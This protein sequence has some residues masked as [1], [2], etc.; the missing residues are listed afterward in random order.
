MKSRTPR[1][2]ATVLRY[3]GESAA[4]FNNQHYL[5][6]AVLLGVAAE[7]LLEQLYEALATHLGSAKA[8]YTAKLN[9]KRWTSQ[10]LEYARARLAPHL[11][12]VTVE[13]RTRV[14]QYLDML[15]QVLKLSRD[16]VG[17]ARPLRIDRE[18]ASMNL[19]AFPVFA[20]IV[21]ALMVQLAIPCTVSS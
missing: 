15:A 18:V 13:F 3:V 2:D 20:G 9:A 21:D 1:A 6:S 17:H 12:E 5:A 4:T 14:E 8:E 11:T 7:A 10:R 19:V 16:D